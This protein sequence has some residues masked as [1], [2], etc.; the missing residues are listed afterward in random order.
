[1][2]WKLSEGAGTEGISGQPRAPAAGGPGERD[3]PH[4]P[5]RVAL[6]SSPVALARDHRRGGDKRLA[7]VISTADT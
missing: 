2:F 3:A 1:M 7:R 5:L 4:Y 6:G